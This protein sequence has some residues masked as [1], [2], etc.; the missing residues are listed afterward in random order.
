MK[1]ERLCPKVWDVHDEIAGYDPQEATIFNLND[2][3]RIKK[4]KNGLKIKHLCH[5]FRNVSYEKREN[6]N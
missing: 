6:T 1:H 5:C 4:R 3:T 2:Y